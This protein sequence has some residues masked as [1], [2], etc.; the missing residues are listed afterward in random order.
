MPTLHVRSVPEDLYLEIQRLAE[1]KNLSL[2]AQVINMLGQ[3]LEDEKRR[4]IQSKALNSIRRRRFVA[5][6]KAPSSLDLLR[7]DRNR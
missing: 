2:S 5:P 7:E 1:T 6:K 4:K 3:A